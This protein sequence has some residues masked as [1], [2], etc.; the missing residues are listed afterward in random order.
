MR[1][2]PPLAVFS[3]DQYALPPMKKRILSGMRPTGKLHLGHYWG[4][5]RNWIELQDEYD[6][7][8]MIADWHALPSEWMKPAAI[9]GNVREVAADWIAAGVDPEKSCVFVQSEVP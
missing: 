5:L 2:P 6:C 1:T 3:A 9:P 8:F 7:Y 4:V